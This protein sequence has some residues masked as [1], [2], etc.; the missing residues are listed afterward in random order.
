MTRI[1]ETRTSAAGRR[2]LE[3]V[4]S[5]VVAGA[6][7]MGK[8]ENSKQKR[9]HRSHWEQ[10]SACNGHLNTPAPRVNRNPDN[11]GKKKKVRPNK[12]VL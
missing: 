6:S 7:V 4:E 5:E 9:N 2:S 1:I 10:R 3:E 11:N 12:G 8:E